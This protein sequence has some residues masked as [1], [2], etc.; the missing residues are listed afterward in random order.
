MKTIIEPNSKE[1]RFLDKVIELGAGEIIEDTPKEDKKIEK[2][3]DELTYIK[4]VDDKTFRINIV[5]K[6]NNIIDKVNGESNE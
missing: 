5:H 3:S 2:L 6:I 4:L 1:K